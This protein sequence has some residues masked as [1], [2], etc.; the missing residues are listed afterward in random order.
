MSTADT[1]NG[2]EPLQTSLRIISQP[3][4]PIFVL[5]IFICVGTLLR[6][7]NLSTRSLWFDEA[8]SWMLA[9]QFSI[10]ES[11][12]RTALDV[13]PP[14][15][16]LVLRFWIDL[17]GDSIIA[18][19]SMSIVFADLNVLILYFFCRDCL[20]DLD[21]LTRSKIGLFAAGFLSVSAYHIHWS[22]ETR[23]YTFALFLT[24][25]S[26][27]LLLISLRHSK[28]L[29]YWLFYAV[30]SCALMYTH[31][32]GLF[33]VFGQGVY[34]L[35]NLILT[36]KGSFKNL[37]LS[38]K[39]RNATIAYALILWGYAPWLPILMFQK[40]QV[41]GNYWIGKMTIWTIPDAL[42]Q[43][44]IPNNNYEVISRT[45]AAILTVCILIVMVFFLRPLT[46]AKGLILT[47]TLSPIVIA[48]AVSLSSVSIIVTRH[49]LYSYI[50]ILC[51]IAYVLVTRFSRAVNNALFLWIIVNLLAINFVFRDELSISEKPGIRGAVEELQTVWKEGDLVLVR[52][53]C[54][55]FSVKYYLDK[56]YHP[57]LYLPGEKALH[58]T[59]APILVKD[60][61]IY[62][63]TLNNSDAKHAWVIDTSGFTVGLSH[64]ALPRKWVLTPSPQEFP[65]V[66]FFQK[67][68]FLRKATKHPSVL[69]SEK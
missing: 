16:Y 38:Q 39:F 62:K 3:I 6:L 27:W 69:K 35:V 10:S 5:V 31:N 17:F 53:P 52:H 26:A 1:K 55:Y 25:A 14:L 20:T 28:S 13:H 21:Y 49:F 29:R 34:C 46:W 9:C 12:Y 64:L 24:T 56:K 61:L 42:F 11:I 66:Y 22:Q 47:G 32:Y 57:K 54:I 33:V 63:S 59:G 15:Y 68:I 40:S 2:R 8:F 4:N 67:S 50:F 44:V 60:D 19:R 51:I 43:L 30:V 45:G 37:I 58:Y 7:P 65:D 23:M 48:S 41:Q 18:M 36:R